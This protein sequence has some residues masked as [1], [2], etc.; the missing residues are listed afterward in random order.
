M[1]P[2]EFLLYDAVEGEQIFELPLLEN[3]EWIKKKNP[4]HVIEISAYDQL[5]Q[6]S[7]DLAEAMRFITF[8]AKSA[9][10]EFN[11]QKAEHKRPYIY[12][13]KDISTLISQIQMREKKYEALLEQANK[14][15]QFLKKEEM[16]LTNGP[17]DTEK[18]YWIT[19]QS[20]KA[21]KKE[22]GIE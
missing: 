5:L 22:Q 20:W 4:L 15:E 16:H 10:E 9:L 18:G 8:K 3:Y 13:E 2:R 1:K 21:F 14:L 17:I 12:N 6:N 19:I 11:E 7:N